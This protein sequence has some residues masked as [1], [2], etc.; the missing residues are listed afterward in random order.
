MDMRRTILSSSSCIHRA[1]HYGLWRRKTSS[2]NRSISGSGIPQVKGTLL[3]YF[4]YHWFNTLWSKFSGG[5]IAIF[6]GLSVGRE[7]PPIQ[8]GACVAEGL[9]NRLCDSRTERNY[10]IAGGASA[11]L[12]AA[13]NALLAGVVFAV[14][15]LF[16]YISLPILLVTMVSAIVAGSIARLTFGA[17]SCSCFS[18][19]GRSSLELLLDDL[20]ARHHLGSAPVHCITSFC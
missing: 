5:A 8:L 16:T 19:S 9:G 20:S 7:G 1:G 18:H 6:A 11:G 12:A 17:S 3:G 4:N 13:F 15:E 14:E 2:K 10:L